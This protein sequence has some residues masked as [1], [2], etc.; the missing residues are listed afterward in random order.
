MYVYGRSAFPYS[1]SSGPAVFGMSEFGDLRKMTRSTRCRRRNIL[2]HLR[3][4]P[5]INHTNISVVRCA[6]WIKT[7]SGLVSIQDRFL[8]QV[9][10]FQVSLCCPMGYKYDFLVCRA[11]KVLKSWTCI[12]PVLNRWRNRHKEVK[13]CTHTYQLMKEGAELPIQAAWLRSPPSSHAPA[14]LLGPDPSI[15]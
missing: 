15:E 11:L 5:L 10:L 2:Q 6:C 3:Q 13:Q 8:Y 7:V 1:K 9:S 14:Y 12:D 4:C